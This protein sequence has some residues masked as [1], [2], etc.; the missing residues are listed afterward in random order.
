MKQR[1][2][3]FL[4]LVFLGVQ[5]IVGQVK[6]SG[7]CSIKGIV[8]DSSFRKPIPFVTVLLFI[9]GT[10][11]P[12]AIQ[13]TKADG[14]YL[15]DSLAGNNYFLQLSF[16]GY[17][18]QR[19][20]DIT[21]LQKNDSFFV[22]SFL[23]ANS[24]ELA[25]VTVFGNAKKRQIEMVQGGYVYNAELSKS[26]NN[27]LKDLLSKVPGIFL[28]R[29]GIKIQGN[30]TVTVI[31]DGRTVQMEGTELYEYLSA[32]GAQ[33][34]ATVT[35]LTSPSAKNEA[36]GTGGIIE[37]KTR[38]PKTKGIISRVS[39]GA[40][41]HDKYNLGII[42]NFNS[43]NF[44]SSVNARYSHTNMY[45]YNTVSLENKFL[46]DLSAPY[47]ITQS[48]SLN[49][50]PANNI[51]LNFGS[52][53][54]LSKR[55]NIATNIQYNI[56]DGKPAPHTTYT[57]YANKNNT[58][59]YSILNDNRTAQKSF[60]Q[61]YYLV[62]NKK[63]AKP[64]R[65]LSADVNV[66]SARRPSDALNNTISFDSRNIIT[67]EEMLQVNSNSK[68][69]IVTSNIDYGQPLDSISSFYMGVRF[70]SVGKNMD[71]ATQPFSLVN[72]YHLKFN[73]TITAG[74]LMYKRK[75][76]SYALTAGLRVENT[77]NRVQLNK[78]DQDS[79]YKRS[80]VDFFPNISIY[81]T[82]SEGKSLNFSYS[83]RINRPKF[84]S[85]SSIIDIS[86]PLSKTVGNPYIN[87]VYVNSF[88]LTYNR[89]WGME[90]FLAI[91]GSSKL[92]NNAFDNFSLYDSVHNQMV[93]SIVNYKGGAM[94]SVNGTVNIQLTKYLSMS[95]SLTVRYVKI[96]NNLNNKF[97]LNTNEA[98]TVFYNASLIGSIGK[99]I[100]VQADGIYSSRQI[101]IQS[102]NS[103]VA[104]MNF[105]IS[106]SF[107]KQQ[108]DLSADVMD[109]FNSNR[110]RGT[111]TADALSASLYNKEETRIF[112]LGISWRFGKS[113][114]TNAKRV[115][116]KTDS[117][118]E[119]K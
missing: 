7:T 45:N 68:T 3:F 66:F 103:G 51:F 98:V 52:S 59:L 96:N 55:S 114:K 87:P 1:G 94:Y 61:Q 85:Y 100:T 76:K 118:T 21:L 81:K 86:N 75:I 5:N 73:E 38:A 102:T 109:I 53:L 10:D 104:Y 97:K 43:K 32:Q 12:Q 71:F 26:I 13:L 84:R 28:D 40:S 57:D 56:S 22:T 105:S 8:S 117:R 31:I 112:S 70:N 60:N 80:Y 82:I 74:Y 110:S 72:S 6:L 91:T 24:K 62:Y 14:T 36:Q 11:K 78:S 50:S 116:P 35:V 111:I 64:G 99:T 119:D 63:F 41:S 77:F 115:T 17:H 46:K 95:N 39:A 54:N 65:V 49:N 30:N 107:K 90:N 106:K 88:D 34:I 58:R 67:G 4:L 23:P 44:S 16:S 19:V 9:K 42:S 15:F 93:D 37:I 79:L 47:Y 20:N 83:R 108:I 48:D 29:S 101:G 25:N 69:A 113:Y 2:L 33:N 89:Q 27:N 92:I 18:T